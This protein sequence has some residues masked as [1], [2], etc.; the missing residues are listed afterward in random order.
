MIVTF[1]EEYLRELYEYGKCSNKRHRFQPEIIKGY[2]RRVEQLQA[3][4]NPEFLYQL[5]SLHFEA[6][7]G[8]KK[9]RFSVRINIQYRVE[10]TLTETQGS[11]I[12]TLCN[13]IELS[14]HYD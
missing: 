11:S 5:N 7:K 13:I 2:K 3:A 12:L 4:P 9:G 10:F 1:E 14:N 8:D 6:L